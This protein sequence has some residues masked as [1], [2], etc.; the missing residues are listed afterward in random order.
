[1]VRYP[2]V[3]TVAEALLSWL[4]REVAPD[5]CSA[6]QKSSKQ[7][8]GTEVHVVMAIH[9]LRLG[10]VEARE[11]VTLRRHNILEGPDEPRM[12]HHW[13]Q[14]VPHQV[15]C[16]FALP[17]NELRGTRRRGK[18]RRQIEMQTGINSAPAG[19]GCRPLGRSE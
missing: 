2:A 15:P 14:P 8:V 4:K 3:E 1:M 12:E 16:E 11:L 6:R 9:P 17:F 19:D 7:N 13:R 5:N 10:A 18:G